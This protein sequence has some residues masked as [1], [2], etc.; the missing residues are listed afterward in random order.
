M[1][2]PAST[3]AAV[4]ASNFDPYSATTTR[5][6]NTS[7][8]SGASRR[9]AALASRR[10]AHPGSLAPGVPG[11]LAP[12]MKQRLIRHAW[13]PAV[14][15]VVVVLVVVLVTRRSE[16]PRE[17]KLSEFQTKIAAHEVK[18]AKLASRDSSV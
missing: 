7:G 16:P 3:A 8:M 18:N 5:P 10:P 15:L 11:T 12:P 17:L 1:P 2:P 13:I 6:R 14:A 9:V 4:S